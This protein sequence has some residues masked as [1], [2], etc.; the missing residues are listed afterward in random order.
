VLN[1]S[2]GGV[3]IIRQVCEKARFEVGYALA[4]QEPENIAKN[5]YGKDG[6]QSADGLKHRV[7][8]A[9]LK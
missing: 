1:A 6:T 4:K 8:H 5:R 3:H 9:S 7:H 2:K